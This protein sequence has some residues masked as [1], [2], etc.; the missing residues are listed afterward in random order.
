MQSQ[1]L[2]INKIRLWFATEL[3]LR[4]MSTGELCWIFYWILVLLNC[5]AGQLKSFEYKNCRQQIITDWRVVGPWKHFFFSMPTPPWHSGN[6][7]MCNTSFNRRFSCTHRQFLSKVRCY[8]PLSPLFD[9]YVWRWNP[10][11]WC[12]QQ[13]RCTVVKEVFLRGMFLS[14]S[15]NSMNCISIYD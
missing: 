14:S 10:N 9:V 7:S 11:A 6:S 1:L 3:A 12:F 13:L 5:R 2:Y 15:F 4:A 8:F